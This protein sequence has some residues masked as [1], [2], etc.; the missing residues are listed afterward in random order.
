MC[1]SRT[2]RDARCDVRRERVPRTARR[3]RGRCECAVRGQLD[4]HHRIAECSAP[5]RGWLLDERMAYTGI[6]PDETKDTAAAFWTRAQAFFRAAGVTVTRVLTDNGSC[7]R[8]R[9][10]RDTLTAAGITH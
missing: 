6:L 3:T 8:S 4:G 5:G 1:G 9:L 7:Y 2:G 10:R